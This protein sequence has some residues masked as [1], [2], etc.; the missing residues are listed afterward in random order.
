[1]HLANLQS[2]KKHFRQISRWTKRIDFKDFLND[3]FGS[4]QQIKKKS[5]LLIYQK[6]ITLDSKI[7]W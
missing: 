5:D 1:M 2:K 7:F 4:D 3:R 6:I